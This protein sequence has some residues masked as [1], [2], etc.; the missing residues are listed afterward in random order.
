MTGHFGQ[1]NKDNGEE[2]GGNDQTVSREQR[3]SSEDSVPTRHAGRWQ[4]AKFLV[5]SPLESLSFLKHF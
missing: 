1:K 5:H 4:R 2:H 3:P